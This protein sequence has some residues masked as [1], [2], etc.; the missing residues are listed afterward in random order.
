VRVA[1]RTRLGEELLP[2]LLFGE[3][4]RKEDSDGRPKVRFCVW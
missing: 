3:E 2:P 4:G 1:V